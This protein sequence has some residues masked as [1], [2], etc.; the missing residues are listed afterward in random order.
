M[1]FYGKKNEKILKI[2]KILK[3]FF[4]PILNYVV[5]VEL[6]HFPQ[7]IWERPKFWDLK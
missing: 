3:I 1:W 4:L 6:H 5:C 7:N 2:L